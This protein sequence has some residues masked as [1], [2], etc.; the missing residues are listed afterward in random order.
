[1]S[2]STERFGWLAGACAAMLLTGCAT[3]PEEDPVQTRLND[4]D[5]RV[6]RIDRIVSNQSLMQMAQRVDAQQEELRGLRGR[7]EELQNEN[8]TLRKQQRDL[9]AD[10]DK[11]LTAATAAA[12]AA[13]TVASNTPAGPAPEADEQGQYNKAMEQLRSRNYAAAVEGFRSLAAAYPNGQMADN[14]QYWLGEAYY[15]TAEYDHAT[16]AFQRVLSV[17]PNSRKAPDAL[18]KLGYT[19]IEQN[20]LAVGR[21]TLQQ[22]VA[23]YPDSDAAKLAADRLAKLPKP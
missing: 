12:A 6:G 19:Q 1:M 23:K 5:A 16:A 9:Y 14:T 4:L 2:T 3:T 22:V 7:I 20:K 15:V 11:R 8:A 18:L 21:A 10:L 13:T 17:W